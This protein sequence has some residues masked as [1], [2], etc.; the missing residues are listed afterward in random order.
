MLLLQRGGVLCDGVRALHERGSMCAADVE[1]RCAEGGF[2]FEGFFAFFGGW[3]SGHFREEGAVVEGGFKSVCVY[4]VS[5]D[6]G[7]G[8]WLLMWRW[9]FI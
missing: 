1:Q 2:G 4:I 9:L 8:A 6:G 7:G 3:L 5:G